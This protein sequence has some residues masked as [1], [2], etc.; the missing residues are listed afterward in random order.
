MSLPKIW[1]PRIIEQL[2]HE[3]ITYSS[4][5]LAKIF[6]VTCNAIMGVCFRN[7]IQIK[8]GRDGKHIK[9]VRKSRVTFTEPVHEKVREKIVTR[10]KAGSLPEEKHIIHEPM[11]WPPANGGCLQIVGEARMLIGC[12]LL[13]VK[14]KPYCAGHCSQNYTPNHYKGM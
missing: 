14:N 12:G 11:P 8:G 10:H 3:A 2:S 13:R 7:G 6:N 1:T 9:R 5:E 4:A